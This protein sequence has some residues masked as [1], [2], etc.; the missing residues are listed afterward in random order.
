MCGNAK[1]ANVMKGDE[2]LYAM[3][4]VLV[5]CIFISHNLL[6]NDELITSYRVGNSSGFIVTPFEL[7]ESGLGAIFLLTV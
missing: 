7:A 2:C 6:E 5:I 1:C 3:S 4:T